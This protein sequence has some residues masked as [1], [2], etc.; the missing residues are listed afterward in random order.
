MYQYPEAK[1]A[2]P[3]KPNSQKEA[4]IKA[5]LL[6]LEKCDTI[7]AKAVPSNDSLVSGN[8]GASLYHYEAYHVFGKKKDADRSRE[9]L[10]NTI[11]KLNDL[12]SDLFNPSYARGITGLGCLLQYFSANQFMDLSIES[13]FS[14]IDH[15]LFLQADAQIKKHRNDWL[16]GAF[17]TIFYFLHRE[18]THTIEQYLDVLLSLLLTKN[19]NGLSNSLIRN[20]FLHRDPTRINLSLSHG[21]TGFLLI[22][23]QA[24]RAGYRTDQI[25]T[26]IKQAVAAILQYRVDPRGTNR[27]FFPFE[28][29]LQENKQACNNRLAWCYGDLNLV[30]LLYETGI[31][32]NNNRYREIA[33]FVGLSSIDRTEFS[34][35]LCTDSHFCH[36]SSGIAQTFKRLHALRALP[37]Y[38]N[39]YLRWISQTISFLKSNLNS[40]R[41]RD[42]ESAF[43]EGLLGP[44]M[45]LLS[46][47][48]E[49]DLGWPK[50]WLL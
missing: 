31:L 43:L 1:L 49:E 7:I 22:L 8:L 19:D 21:Q 4:L 40:G 33:D 44:A 28:I 36:G 2:S 3:R 9:L 14:E 15:Y 25:S 27:Y 10:E 41:F 37:E 6:L 32:F 23:M 13:E 35:T 11:K 47:I 12:K 48:H 18:Q 30:L 26:H 16:H 46:F 17:G 50:F 39:A 38:E 45:V 20:F 34:T 24:L 42:Q 5:A 29:L